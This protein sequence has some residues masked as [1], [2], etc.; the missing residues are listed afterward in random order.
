MRLKSAPDL[1]R[2]SYRGRFRLLRRQ[3]RFFRGRG[4]PFGLRPPLL[5]F[6]PGAL[7]PLQ[8]LPGGVQF[9]ARL[10]ETRTPLRQ[11]RFAGRQVGMQPV[12]AE[13]RL[14]RRQVGDVLT[15][16]LPPLPG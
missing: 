1:A 11:A 12:E 6:L 14:A 7:T 5:L 8:A 10:L 13:A 16:P 15:R 4:R 2:L 3:A 9:E